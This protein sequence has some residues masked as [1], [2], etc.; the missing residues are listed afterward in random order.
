MIALRSGREIERI[1]NYEQNW[2]IKTNTA[3]LKIIPI[4][5]RKTADVLTPDETHYDY[6]GEGVVLGLKITYG[7]TKHITGRIARATQ[8]LKKIKRFKNLKVQ[9]KRK[10]YLAMIRPILTYPIIP[11]VSSSIGPN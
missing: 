9:N 6:E 3:K 5:R 1:N 2:K 4:S 11:T 10:L 7:Y 8:E